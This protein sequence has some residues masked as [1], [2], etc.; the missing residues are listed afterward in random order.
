[1]PVITYLKNAKRINDT[2][3]IVKRMR[4]II[5]IIFVKDLHSPNLIIFTFYFL[6]IYLNFVRIY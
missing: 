1:M 5:I 3:K 2:I 6:F 4:E